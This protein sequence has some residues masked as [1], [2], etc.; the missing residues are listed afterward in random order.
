MNPMTTLSEGTDNLDRVEL[1]AQTADVGRGRADGLGDGSRGGLRPVLC[2]GVVE[3]DNRRALAGR[4]ADRTRLRLPRFGLHLPHVL[5]LWLG[6]LDRRCARGKQGD[7]VQQALG[8]E[9]W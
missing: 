4:L 5:L 8:D 7:Q 3:L 2:V 9:R 1:A 6:G